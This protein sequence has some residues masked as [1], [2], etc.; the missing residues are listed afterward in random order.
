MFRYTNGELDK[1]GG[2][3]TVEFQY[4]DVLSKNGAA[5]IGVGEFEADVVQFQLTDI[6]AK[7]AV[8][9]KNRERAIALL[10]A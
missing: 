8:G 10:L 4:P 2:L 5:G 6:T 1:A 3:Q 9:L 7:N